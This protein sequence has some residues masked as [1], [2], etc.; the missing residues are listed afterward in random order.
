MNPTEPMP[1]LRLCGWCS[2]PHPTGP[3]CQC[4]SIAVIDEGDGFYTCVDC[5]CFFRLDNMTPITTGI[6]KAAEH[7]MFAEQP[8]ILRA[9]DR[10]G[11]NG[12]T[13]A[14]LVGGAAGMVAVLFYALFMAWEAAQ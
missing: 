10:R 5:R 14:V 4:G 1:M 12:L 3:K 2:P 11:S 13:A 9:P 6:C 8:S 7:M